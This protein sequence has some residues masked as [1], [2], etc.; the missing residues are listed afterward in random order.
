MG[1]I[2]YIIKPFTQTDWELF[3][4]PLKKSKHL[5]QIFSSRLIVAQWVKRDSCVLG[6][7]HFRTSTDSNSDRLLARPI[8][9]CRRFCY[10][11]S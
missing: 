4:E 3:F 1:D 10:L 9:F 2:P 7:P 8:D 5:R 6:Q 11:Q